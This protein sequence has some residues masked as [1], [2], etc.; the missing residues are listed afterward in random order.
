MWGISA[1]CGT[2]AIIT[3]GYCGEEIDFVDVLAA[4]NL[5]VAYLDEVQGTAKHLGS[6]IKALERKFSRQEKLKELLDK[7]HDQSSNELMILVLQYDDLMQEVD[8]LLYW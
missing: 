1:Y 7:Q 2:D 5:T 6:E 3:C 4:Q 8:R